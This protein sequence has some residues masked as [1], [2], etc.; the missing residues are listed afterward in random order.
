MIIGKGNA[1]NAWRKHEARI[2]KDR[3]ER[4]RRLLE[5]D[6]EQLE[7]GETGTGTGT[8][9]DDDV[10]VDVDVQTN[11]NGTGTGTTTTTRRVV[12]NALGVEEGTRVT[13]VLKGVPKQ[14]YDYYQGD[15]PVSFPPILFSL[16]PHE[17]KMTVLNFT[18]TRNTEY[19]GSV[20]SKVCIH[21]FL[22]FIHCVSFLSIYI[23][24]YIHICI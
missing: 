14:L 23:Y 12:G 9:A 5:M 7:L 16:F 24:I 3:E 1:A 17:H 21:F 20:R 13:V 8:G 11:T 4:E 19:E 15:E 18:V 10:D 22:P 6:L 2:V